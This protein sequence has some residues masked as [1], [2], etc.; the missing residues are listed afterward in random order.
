MIGT[1]IQYAIY[2]VILVIL[3]IPLGAYIK[4]AMN[5]EKTFLSRV[6]I[7]CE[8]LVYKV[9]HVN[10]HEEMSWKKY[11]VSVFDFFRCRTHLLV[12]VADVTRCTDG[13]S[14]RTF[15]G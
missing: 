12:W 4:K 14:P 1:I 5:G 8:K 13:E 15:R 11:T 10:E 7:P 3:A 9:M 6:L 2:L